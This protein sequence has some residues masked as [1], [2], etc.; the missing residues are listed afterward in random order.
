V[1]PLLNEMAIKNKKFLEKNLEYLEKLKETF[2][3]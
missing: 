2:G 1:N 3:L